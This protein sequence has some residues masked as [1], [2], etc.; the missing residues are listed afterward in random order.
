MIRAPKRQIT[1]RRN[2][3]RAEAN[4]NETGSL[5]DILC[6]GELSFRRNFNIL[7]QLRQYKP[8]YFP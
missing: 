1:L 8:N 6:A 4:A 5:Y 7:S 3:Q 2:G